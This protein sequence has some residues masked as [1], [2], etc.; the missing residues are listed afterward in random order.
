VGLLAA[1]ALAASLA[2]AS[3]RGILWPVCGAAIA[4]WLA[5]DAR[6]HHARYTSVC[7]ATLAAGVAL[8]SVSADAAG[9]LA[10]LAAAQLYLVAG[11]RKLRSRGFM[12]GRVLLDNVVY[13]ACQ[14]AAGNH[15]F[16]RV[17]STRRLADQ[18]ERGTLLRACRVASVATAAG[19]LTVGIA[20]TG[21]VPVWV[22]FAIAIPMHIGFT[23]LSPPRLIPFTVA[24]LGLLAL[25]TMHP[26]LGV[27]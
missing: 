24:S 17:I 18:L 20:A 5:R 19:E 23:L 1:G 21:L 9:L 13:A 16:L 14:A 11:L 2:L 8:A 7:I 12:S 22:T 3:T 10:S 27:W 6:L 15:E 26:A 25:A 4:V